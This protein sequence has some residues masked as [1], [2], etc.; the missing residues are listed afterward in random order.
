MNEFIVVTVPAKVEGG[1]KS[2]ITVQRDEVITVSASGRASYNGGVTYPDGTRFI[3]GKYSGAYMAPGLL[4]PGAP[5][6][7]LIARVGSGP[8]LAV[9][10]C[11]TFRA[12]DAGEVTV[13]YNDKPGQ[14]GD[15]AGEYVATIENHGKI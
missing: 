15:N 3:E 12:Q 14:Y 7:A 10:S 9:G 2:G 8:W 1:V 11:Q 13:A 4:L 5:A 6:G